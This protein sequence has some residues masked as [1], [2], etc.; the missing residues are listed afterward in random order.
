MVNIRCVWL[1]HTVNATYA[2]TTRKEHTLDKQ[3]RM[4]TYS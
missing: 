1:I 2:K 3:K 4:I